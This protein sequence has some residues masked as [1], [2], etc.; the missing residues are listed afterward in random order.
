MCNSTVCKCG[1]VIFSLLLGVAA[2]LLYGFGLLGLAFGAIGAAVIIA[3]VTL[4]ALVILYVLSVLC[5]DLCG[6]SR[7]AAALCRNGMF[8]AIG[9]AGTILAGLLT[10]SLS[11]TPVV[12]AIFVGITFFFFG[13]LITGIICLLESLCKKECRRCNCDEQ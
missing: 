9:A 3:A 4:L 1:A 11:A 7:V 2:G 10:V 13:L 5:P 12:I 8:V 6:N